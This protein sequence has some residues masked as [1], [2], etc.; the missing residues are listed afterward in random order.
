[1]QFKHIL[2]TLLA[3]NVV[4]AAPVEKSTDLHGSMFDKPVLRH[5][6]SNSTNV[7]S[8]QLHGSMFD[9]PVLRT[10]KH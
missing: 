6:E 1:M 9:V 3:L 2:T 5:H 4:F 7:A 10:R 8:T